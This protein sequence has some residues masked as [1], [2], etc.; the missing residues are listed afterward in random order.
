M[1]Y[2]DPYDERNRAARRRHY[3]K[4]KAVY[5]QRA[6]DRDERLRQISIEARQVPCFDCGVHYPYYVMDFDHR[7]DQPKVDG[8]NQMVRKGVG[9]QKLRDEMAKCDVVCANCHRQRTW[10][11]DWKNASVAGLEPA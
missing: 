8:L 2:K 1:A 6:R 10:E 7:G 5:Q 9:E 3:E 4:N 11:R